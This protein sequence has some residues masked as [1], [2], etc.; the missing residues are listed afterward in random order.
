LAWPILFRFKSIIVVCQNLRQTQCV[1]CHIH[2]ND[3]SFL[4][5]LLS[6]HENLTCLW[7]AYVHFAEVCSIILHSCEIFTLYTSQFLTL[8]FTCRNFLELIRLTRE[9]TWKYVGIKWH[10]ILVSYDGNHGDEI[11]WVIKTN[12]LL[13]QWQSWCLAL[14]MR[15]HRIP[16]DNK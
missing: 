15:I 6:N 10:D 14:S 3:E 8:I 16:I 7:L 13:L 9:W 4:I 11:K 5:S 12:L 2:L 1:I